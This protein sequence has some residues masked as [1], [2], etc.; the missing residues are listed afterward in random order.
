MNIGLITSLEAL[1]EAKVML[2]SLSINNDLSKKGE[3][4]D[5]FVV[6]EAEEKYLKCLKDISNNLRITFI[7]VDSSLIN[8]IEI[9]NRWGRYVFYRLIVYKL[10][11]ETL[12]RIL[13]LDVDIIIDG[14]IEEFY[15]LNFNNKSIIACEDWINITQLMLTT[16]AMKKFKV[17]ENKPYFN[18]GVLL[19]NL[20][21]IRK[22]DPYDNLLKLL[23]ETEKYFKY[24]DQDIYNIYFIDDVKIVTS[25]YNY[26]ANSGIRNN[27]IKPIIIHYAGSVKPNSIKYGGLYS[28]KYWIYHLQCNKFKKNDIKNFIICKVLNQFYKITGQTAWKASEKIT[29]KVNKLVKIKKMVNKKIIIFGWSVWSYQILKLLQKQNIKVHTI[30]DNDSKMWGQICNIPVCSAN[31]YLSTYDDNNL[32]LIASGHFKSMK[33]Q[34]KKYGYKSNKHIIKVLS[35]NN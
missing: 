8:N 4:I 3:K 32:I 20:K 25:K 19:M 24:A 7:K 15:N 14:N 5:V 29:N 18:S 34:A 6:S 12:D 11:P 35:Y 13:W 21:K 2:Y 23:K 9:N 16:A 10:L 33:K 31:D 22:L 26:S 1:E 30:I 28:N 17:K 27:K